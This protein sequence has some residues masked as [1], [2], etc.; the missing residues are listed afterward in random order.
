MLKN[1]F[2][3]LIIS[4]T[5]ISCAK[6]EIVDQILDQENIEKQMVKLDKGFTFLATV[7]STSPYIGLFG[8][9]WGI[10]NSFTA[11]GIV[12]TDLYQKRHV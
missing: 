8:T 4:L 1:I 2:L 9:V 3:I 5:F 6:K 10:M 12:F 11:P 7:G